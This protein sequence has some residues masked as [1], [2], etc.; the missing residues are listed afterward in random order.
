[1]MRRL[2]FTLIE[3]LVVISII[4]ILIGIL[5][6]TLSLAKSRAIKVACGSNLRQVGLAVHMYTQ[7]Y[8]D[9]YPL[10]RYMP[11]PFLSGDDDPS[12]PETLSA[13][14]DPR[15][16]ET[17]RIYRCPGDD[18]V[19]DLSGTSYNYHVTLGGQTIEEYWLVRFLGLP[20]TRVWISRDYDGGL[21]DLEDGSQIDVP[22][23]HEKRNLLFADGHV[24]QYGN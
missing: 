3:L 23:F 22:F 1:M 8:K 13:Y 11:E 9:V 14:L 4:A 2:G 19:Y 10:A 6:P 20:E 7:D 5:L 16:K 21:F 17:N 24:G 15:D 12:L 18:W